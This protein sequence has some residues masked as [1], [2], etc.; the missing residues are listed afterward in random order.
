MKRI[1]RAALALFIGA[2][3]IYEPEALTSI[4]ASAIEVFGKEAAKIESRK[5][6]GKR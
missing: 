5:K 1:V 4:L 3:I 6:K 2:A